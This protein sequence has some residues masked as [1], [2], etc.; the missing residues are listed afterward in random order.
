MNITTFLY[1][2][3][4]SIFSDPFLASRKVSCG[5]HEA[6][7][8]AQ[9]VQENVAMEELGTRAGNRGKSDKHGDGW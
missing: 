1:F 3:F 9:C 5:G 8:C 4:P 7:S 6:A 2:L